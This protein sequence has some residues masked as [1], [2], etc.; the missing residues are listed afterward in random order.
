MSQVPTCVLSSVTTTI[1]VRATHESPGSD[2][3]LYARARNKRHV[4]YKLIKETEGET[5]DES[6]LSGGNHVKETSDECACRLAQV[7]RDIASRDDSEVV[8]GP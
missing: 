6:R 4:C 7:A 1:L 5:S 8:N 2:T 3:L